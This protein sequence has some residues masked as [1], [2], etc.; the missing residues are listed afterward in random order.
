LE[1]AYHAEVLRPVGDKPGAHAAL[2]LAWNAKGLLVHVTTNDRTPVESPENGALWAGDSFEVFM[3][4]EA[5]KNDCFQFLF[6]PGR[7]SMEKQP[8]FFMDDKRLKK[9]PL[10]MPEFRVDE[11]SAK[12]YAMS[13]LIPWG[14]FLTA[15]V[16]GGMIRLRISSFDGIAEWNTLRR[17]WFPR[18]DSY[19]NASLTYRVRIATV[20][21]PPQTSVASIQVNRHWNLELHLLAAPEMAGK[22]VEV[23]IDDPKM[24]AGS[25]LA[26][27][28]DGSE[29]IF[30]LPAEITAI[31]DAKLQVFVDGEF[32][33]PALTLPDPVNERKD[34]LSRCQ[35][36]A[37]HPI[38]DGEAFPLIDFIDSEMA[39]IVFGPYK[40]D[41]RYFDSDWN[42]VTAA[43]KPGRYGALVTIQTSDGLTDTRRIT[44][45][46][47]PKPYTKR[48]GPYGIHIDFPD[49]FGLHPEI[50]KREVNS[51]Q[52]SAS[53][54]I[55]E[56]VD[57]PAF[58]I[59][60]LNDIATNPAQNHGFYLGSL[61]SEWWTGLDRKLGQHALYQYRVFLPE[62]YEKNEGK[63]WPLIVCLHG[64]G[65][66]GSDLGNVTRNG[67]P[68]KVEQGEKYPFIIVAPLCP[69]DERWCVSTLMELLDEVGSKYRVDA[70]RVY[71]TGLSL[72]GY[73]TWEAAARHPERFAAVAPICGAANPE[74]APRLAKLPIWAFHGD[75]DPNVPIVQDKRIINA[76]KKLKAP[77]KFTVYPGCG[78]D[79]WTQTYDNPALYE[80]FLQHSR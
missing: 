66:R 53:W 76:L 21:A 57:N 63:L 74:L 31:K 16:A 40:L 29:L 58:F 3:G 39:D 80:W 11:K 43:E 1:Q 51:I 60:G 48:M 75:A 38:F 65:E 73:G 62:D 36:T 49:A 27:G 14:N 68:K 9:P 12:G 17:I 28:P 7:T 78:H 32:L 37:Q 26:G 71:L 61:E 56:S 55:Q 35:V 50:V 30:P 6:S 25:L 64:S 8:R 33:P 24:N 44:L 19:S 34:L 2:A 5:E 77:V 4:A 41:I 15:P 20:A 22:K 59:A 79:S 72:G 70:K 47:T 42:E 52:N 54:Q 23:G 46:K 18:A 67:L 45:F 13:A 10:I 69:A